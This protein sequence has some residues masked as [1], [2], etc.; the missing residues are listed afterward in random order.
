MAD[1]RERQKK[2]ETDHDSV[3][4]FSSSDGPW[5]GVT[6]AYKEAARTIANYYDAGMA[7]LD[8]SCGNIML[9]SKHPKVLDAVNRIDRNSAPTATHG[10]EHDSQCIGIAAGGKCT[11]DD[12]CLDGTCKDRR[13]SQ[14]PSRDDGRCHPPGTCAQDKYDKKYAEQ[15]RACNESFNSDSFKNQY[16]FPCKDL[17]AV[18]NRATACINTRIDVMSC[19]RGGDS[20]HHDTLRE[21]QQSLK[22]CEDLLKAK[23]DSKNCTD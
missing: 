10:S 15:K 7:K 5:S 3:T 19:F 18:C 2:M 22:K 6:S 16:D 14:C 17:E 8:S 21:V 20:R 11:R 23:R 13:C 1:A 9:L 12:Q 4:S